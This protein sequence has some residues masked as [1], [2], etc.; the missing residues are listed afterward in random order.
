MGIKLQISRKSLIGRVFG[1]TWGKLFLL[2]A[3]LAVT[4]SVGTFTYFYVKYARLID[5]KLA[6][7]PFANTS[8]LYAAPH[9]VRVGDQETPQGIAEYLQH[10]GYLESRNSRMGW[11]MRRAGAIDVYPGPDSMDDEPAVIKFGEGKVSEILSLRDHTT[12][13]MY[14]LEPELISNMFDKQR[15]KR[16]IVAFEDIPSVMKNAILAAEDKRFFAHAG[17]DPVGIL[18]AVYVDLKEGKNNQGASTISQQVARSI[19]LTNERTWR[20]KLPEALI[21][22][23]L[24][25][26]LSKEK[27]FEY[28]A[29]AIYLGQHGS[30]SI[31]GFREGAQVYFGK[32][33]NQ[34]TLPEA[35]TIAG[36]IQAPISRNPFKYPDRAMQRR[37]IVLKMMREAGFISD[38]EMA[39]AAAA[40]LE[41]ARENRGGSEASYFVD[42]VTDELQNRFQDTDFS[43]NS[44]RVYTTLDMDLQRDAVEAI[45]TGIQEAD[46]ALK[47]KWKN[48]GTSPE[49]PL[50][51]VALVALDPKTGEVKALVGGRDYGASQLNRALSKRQPG[52]V[53]KP[54]VY[55]AA[56]QTGL[57]GDPAQAITPATHVVDEPTT[58]TWEGQT[59][60]PR[61]YTRTF[62]GDVTVRQALAKSL[63][64]PTVKLAEQAGYGKVAALAKAAGLNNDVKG[65]PSVALGSYV[66]TPVEIASAY[67]MFPNY[68]SAYKPLF[69]KSVR[70]QNGSVM[71]DLKTEKKWVMDPRVAYLMTNLMEEVMRSGTGAGARSRGFL[72]PAAGKTGTSHDGWFAGFTSELLCVVWVG[73]DDNRELPL[74]GA[75]SA[76][77]IWTEFM[78]RAHQH[79]EYRNVQGFSPP[80]GITS[81]EIDPD[82]GELATTACPKP[83][84]EFFI[85]GTEPVTLCHLHAGGRSVQVSGWSTE[86][87]APDPNV[88]SPGSSAP[89]P[90]R[91][92]S[93][94]QA[95]VIMTPPQPKQ[96]KPP[97][98]KGLFDRLK[99]IFK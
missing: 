79:R 44:Y 5:T 47:K 10:C 71:S 73:F 80:E 65:T 7:G 57:N 85:A 8:L 21:T 90:P 43:S 82:T 78:K 31:H 16:R 95:E 62:V 42:L 96:D 28:Y 87:P 50:V 19:W 20:R 61:N 91:R 67:T 24:E 55:A 89:L 97:E 66:T 59:Y 93:Q 3:F 26:K 58:F 49:V 32:E 98:K 37:N 35:A 22:L 81:V 46:K 54:F 69:I 70:T 2:F 14:Q 52:S 34:L 60:E 40:P 41:L 56:L 92:P 48:Y 11:Y 15:Q 68:G 6:S 88:A 4:T 17:F 53:F 83:R 74:D 86:S 77:P 94:S 84:V 30:F 45:R 18:R 29:N 64:I 25:Q 13:T 12:R 23:H 76:L 27:I 51:Q 39:R 38:Q 72:L 75:H 33:L 1:S 99:G 9:L 63:N 36:L